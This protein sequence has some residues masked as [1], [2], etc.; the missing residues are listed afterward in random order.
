MALDRRGARGTR[1]MSLEVVP[2][3]PPGNDM[4]VEVL[5][6]SSQRLAGPAVRLIDRRA[7]LADVATPMG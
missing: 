5:L 2:W 4:A 7:G 6:S 3:M 1:S